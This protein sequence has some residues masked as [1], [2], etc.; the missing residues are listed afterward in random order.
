MDDVAG[1]VIG[2]VIPAVVVFGV[3]A[4][5]VAVLVWGVRRAR[6][7]PAARKRAEAERLEAGAVLVRLDDAIAELELEASTI[8]AVT[9]D[10]GEALGE[11]GLSFTHDFTLMRHMLG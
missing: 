7:S 4:L 9:A 5:A 10:H 1:T 8:V 11:H 6:R 3:A 2:W